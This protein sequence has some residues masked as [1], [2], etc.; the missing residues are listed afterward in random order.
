MQPPE[1]PSVTSLRRRGR[2]RTVKGDR[3]GPGIG[4]LAAAARGKA[5]A[6]GGRTGTL[7]DTSTEVVS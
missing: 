5:T 7:K 4:E 1:W 3:K 6:K 2:S